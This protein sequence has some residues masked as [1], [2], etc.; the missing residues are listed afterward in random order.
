MQKRLLTLFAAM[1]MVGAGCAT[2]PQNEPVAVPEPQQP[3]EGSA[4]EAEALPTIGDGTE[5]PG[6]IVY[7]LDEVA[8]HATTTDCWM[9]IGGKVYEM[10]GYAATHPGETTVLDGCGKN[11]T[12]L[13]GSRT[14]LM[15]YEIGTLGE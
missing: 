11:A 15:D 1:A 5:L 14:D 13:L 9:A 12:Q 6:D 10:T 7:S 3:V 8:Q 2:A 4:A